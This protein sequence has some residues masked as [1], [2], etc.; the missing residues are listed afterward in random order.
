MIYQTGNNNAKNV[1]VT[2]A[3]PLSPRVND[4]FKQFIMSADKQSHLRKNSKVMKKYYDEAKSYKSSRNLDSSKRLK[5]S[6]TQLVAIPSS[7]R[8]TSSNVDLVLSNMSATTRNKKSLKHSMT[9]K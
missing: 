7:S 9:R 5:N 2:A 6:T 4:S 3:N 1:N 8:N